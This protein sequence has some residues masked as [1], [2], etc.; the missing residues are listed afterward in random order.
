M[1]APLMSEYSD[2]VV[3]LGLFAPSDAP[4]LLEGDGDSEHRRRFEFPDGF[5]PSLQHSQAVI[6]RWEGE[7]AAGRRFAFAVRSATNGDLLGGC[8][9]RPLGNRTA[10]LSY[11]TYPRH[12]RRGVASR[13]VMLACEVASSEFDFH[14]VHVLADPDNIVSRHVAVRNGFKEVGE[15]DGRILYVLELHSSRASSP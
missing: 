4:V 15:Q 6:R 12:R 7:R 14:I 3:T 11:W 2:G 1:D 9:L 5:V 13:T 10:N 8:E